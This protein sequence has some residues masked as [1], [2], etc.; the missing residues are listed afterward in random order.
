[1]LTITNNVL[2]GSKSRS[3]ALITA[4]DDGNVL[5]DRCLIM[6]VDEATR[7]GILYEPNFRSM[8]VALFRRFIV[9]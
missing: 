7:R 4:D 3:A 1:M 2:I 8:L 6:D 5:I 9:W